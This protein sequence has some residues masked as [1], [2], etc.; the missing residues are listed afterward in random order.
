MRVPA[1]GGA[2]ARTSA[3]LFWKVKRVLVSKGASPKSDNIEVR[4]KRFSGFCY[5]AQVCPY[6]AARACDI[7]K[8][9]Q[10][11]IL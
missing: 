5:T 8:F 6:F 4:I 10:S 3:N 7:F 1:L 11:S 2:R 9:N